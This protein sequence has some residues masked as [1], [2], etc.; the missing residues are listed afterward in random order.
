MSIV[1]LNPPKENLLIQ[2]IVVAVAVLLFAIKIL[3]YLITRSVSVLTDAIESIANVGA[4]FIGLFS[5]Y[6]SAQPKDQ[7]HPYGHGKAEFLSAGVEGSLIIIAG[8]F[9]IYKSIYSIF[10][11]QPLRQLDQGML[12]IALTAVIN[13]MMGYI[14]VYRG[15]KNNS[16]ALIA[17][18]K[19][20]QS[21][22]YTTLG[23]IAGLILI[24]FTNVLWLDSAIALFFAVVIIITGYQIIRSSVAGIMDEADLGL[25]KK[26]VELLDKNRQDNWV[27]LHNLRVIKF[28]GQLHVDCHLT[29]PWYLNVHEAHAEIDKLAALI[30]N[31]FGNSIELFVHSDG[32]LYF[33]CNI[34]SKD[35]CHV[36]QKPFEHKI[37]WSTKNL[38]RDAKHGTE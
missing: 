16:L 30:K 22:T 18:G 19:H 37:P 20:L 1:N 27:D 12:L 5:L 13:Y 29:V 25:L 32:C 21:D 38:L 33:Q 10:Y 6:I 36:R 35:D 8:L 23:I 31:E 34:C 28:G 2:K 3:A 14:S 4:G 26:M 7:N 11:P 15:K 9:I 24:Y 17:S